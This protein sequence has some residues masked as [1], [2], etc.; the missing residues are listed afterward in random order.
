MSAPPLTGTA[1]PREALRE[2][3]QFWTPDWVA[4]AM[5]EYALGGG[6]DHVFDPAVGAGAFFRAAR[7]VASVRGRRVALLGMERY[8]DV[9]Q[10]AHAAGVDGAALRNVAIGDFALAPPARRYRAIIGNPPYIRH[11]RIS[12]AD[13]AALARFSA[14]LLGRPLDGRAGLHVYFLLR[15]LTLLE[16]GGRLA[17][18]LPADTCEG[19]FAGA[20]WQ[21]IARGYR[22]DAAVTFEPA[23]TPFPGVDT[24]ALVVL[25][26]HS[27]PAPRVR[28]VRCAERTMSLSRWIARGMQ[29]AGAP[30]LTLVDRDLDEA[31]RTGLSRAPCDGMRD[32][33]QLGALARVVRGVATGANEFFFL[34]AARASALGLPGEFL[35]PAIGRTRDLDTGDVLERK[36]LARLDA[37]GRPT[38]LLAI[39]PLPAAGLP[40]AVRAYIAQGE[41]RRLHERPLIRTRRPWYRMERREPP[42]FLFAYLG[43]RNARFVRNAAGAVPLTGFLCVYPRHTDPRSLER[44]G[45][46]LAH[47]TTLANLKLVG[48]SYGGGAIKVEPRALERLPI[49]RALLGGLELP[50]ATR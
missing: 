43:R 49:P 46:A 23:A 12:A 25:I 21:W 34:T 8:A 19:V 29:A 31:L 15:A 7:R 26:E 40:S 9:L 4:D 3:G 20:L 50:A 6:A 2:K 45:R 44:L 36:A 38:L 35:S 17:F 5:A 33:V 14:A 11:H 1:I 18:I 41:A 37:A 22:L 42:P 10:Q 28:W 39:P 48:K 16:P 32:S 47:P 24:N 27:A 30:G 13:K